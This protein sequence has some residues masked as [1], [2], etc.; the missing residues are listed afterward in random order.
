M[1]SYI[2]DHLYYVGNRHLSTYTWQASVKQ[3]TT[4]KETGASS[5]PCSCPWLAPPQ[6]SGLGETITGTN[7]E[8]E[9]EEEE[10]AMAAAVG[11][12][13]LPFGFGATAGG[14]CF[15]LGATGGGFLS[16]TAGEEVR[17]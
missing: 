9:E 7:G 2:F 10:R 11:G 1:A 4:S 13:G 16:V 6:R 5:P 12:P 8:D 17:L 14:F 3:L 15:G